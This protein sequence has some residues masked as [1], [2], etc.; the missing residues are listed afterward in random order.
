MQLGTMTVDATRT[1]TTNAEG[2]AGV[3]IGGPYHNGV[4]DVTA[5]GRARPMRA[6][7]SA[8]RPGRSL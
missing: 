4:H 8:V 5:L 1:A 3:D 2:L 6:V 7:R